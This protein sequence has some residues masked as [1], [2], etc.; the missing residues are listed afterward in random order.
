MIGQLGESEIAAV[1]L[2]N[3]LFFLL[4]LFLFGICSGTGIFVAQFW[5]KGDIKNIRRVLGLSILCGLGVSGLFTFLALGLPRQVLGIYTKDLGVIG[6]GSS[7]LGIVGLSYMMTAITY[8]Y[9]FALRN[10]A[11]PKIPMLLSTIAVM[12]NAVFN[13]ILIFGKLGF[14]AMGVEG[15]AIATVI[16]RA[17]EL[18]L[19]L[20]VVY[21]H[22]MPVAARLKD[23]VD[24]S[25]SFARKFFDTTLP[26]IFNEGLWALGVSA[27][28]V[29]FARMGT[30]VVAAVNIAGTVER[31][32]M[33]FFIGMS[34]ACAFMVGNAIGA[35]DEEK[36]VAYAKKL[37]V[38]GP[39]TAVLGGLIVIGSSSQ[40][41]SLF[42]VSD[43]VYGDARKVLIAAALVMPVRTFNWIN[44]VGVL[45]GGGDTRFSLKI[46]ASA[47]WCIGVPVG[48]ITGLVLGLPIA[49]VYPIVI[50]SEQIFKGVLGVKRLM[51]GKWINNLSEQLF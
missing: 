27:Y 33:V 28:S 24:I 32:A 31:M 6:L 39:A 4:N 11:Q 17:L 51:S 18:V 47:V 9:S 1:G 34:H 22:D 5:G 16:A 8:A 12:T 14:P 15:A 23:M 7:Y 25:A 48:Y 44:I 37:A 26:V 20:F 42:K 49:F 30:G 41:L 10:T 45:R 19:V 35:G 38:F 13:Y 50:F 40:I 43:V 3:E 21:R 29:I 2:A 36:A 46:D